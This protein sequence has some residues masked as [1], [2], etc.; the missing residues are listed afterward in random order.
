MG[1]GK[2]SQPSQRPR[3]LTHG[4]ACGPDGVCVL[5]RRQEA[6]ASGPVA[7]RAVTRK[8]SRWRSVAV[9][10][11]CLTVPAL[12]LS[13]ELAEDVVE[14]LVGLP[15][16]STAVAGPAAAESRSPSPAADTVAAK[17]ARIAQEQADLE[18][19]LAL[20][21]QRRIALTE[22]EQARKRAREAANRQRRA[23]EEAE[24]DRRRASMLKADR[25]KRALR[26]ARDRVETVL[27]S[28]PW[29]R[30]CKDARRFL[31]ERGVRYTEHNV[32]RDEAAKSTLRRLNPRRS[33]P[34]FDIDGAV[35]VGFSARRIET[36]LD[37]AARKRARL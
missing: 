21:D 6:G 4:L 26:Y 30:A 15:G 12:A 35:V 5:C 24:Q 25:E 11:A 36:A 32:Q 10:A 3:C 37:R 8:R 16:T 7:A 1:K 19:Q 13:L 27:Y 23:R 31:A 22:A 29:C 28:T 14:Q 20:A 33:V 34:T 9:V 18:R 2:G 17:A